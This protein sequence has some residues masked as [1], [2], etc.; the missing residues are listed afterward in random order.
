ML[1]ARYPGGLWRIGV[2]FGLLLILAAAHWWAP[3]S[4]AVRGLRE[5]RA[6]PDLHPH[7]HEPARHHRLREP[8]RRPPPAGR[9][10][11][12]DLRRRALRV[13]GAVHHPRAH[14]GHDA[15]LRE[16]RV[17]R[18][19][20]RA[21]PPRPAPPARVPPRDHGRSCSAS[22]SATRST[23][24]FPAAPP[25]LVLVYEFTQDPPGLPA[26]V[27]EPVRA[28]VRAAAAWTAAPPSRR[29]TPRC[30]WSRSSTR[31]AT[32]AGGSGSCCRSA[33]AC[34]SST[35]YLRHHY[36]VDLFAGWALAPL[37]MWIGPQAD[38]WWTRRQRALGLST[39]LGAP[40]G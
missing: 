32:C 31:G 34:G 19:L 5:V 27:L 22:T 25:R 15:V 23:S 9:A 8:P 30:R 38:A 20:H 6:L 12:P 29:C 24:L 16:L 14:R 2:A 37:A 1:G 10:R 33:W 4:R 18:A 11:P 21:H 7:L 36:V 28:R 40:S 26:P 13:G 39:A 17:D 3:R 35:V